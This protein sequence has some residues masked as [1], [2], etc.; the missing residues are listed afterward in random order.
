MVAAR[1]VFRLI[2]YSL[3]L[4][5]L[6]VIPGQTAAQDWRPT[7]KQQ[8]YVTKRQAPVSR[9]LSPRGAP[10]LPP[11]LRSPTMPAVVVP[12]TEPNDTVSQANLIAFGDTVTGVIDP[13]E[14]V[15]YFAFDV[16][17]ETTID[18]DVDAAQAG[19]PLDAVIALF[20]VDSV[21]VLA[22][23]DDADGLDSR[24]VYS[25]TTAGRY[26][27]AIA[28]LGGGG[29]PQ[30]TY[31]LAFGTFDFA[32][33]EVEPNN[34]PAEANPVALGDTAAGVITPEADVDY[35]SVDI[36]AETFVDLDV[37]AS[38][39]GSP[40]DAF[41]VLF[42]VDGT[43][44]LAESDDADGLDSRIRYF[45][46]ASGRY[47]VAIRDLGDRGGGGFFYM[48]SFG[49]AAPGPGDP[50]TLFAS[51]FEGPWGMAFDGQGEL[52]VAETFVDQVSR[53]T[54][55]GTV[56][57]LAT[58]IPS[59]QGAAFDGF[60]ELLVTSG[61]GNVYKVSSTG[62]ATAFITALNS[63]V[64]VT[65]SPDGNIWVADDG[66]GMLRRYDAFGAL[67]ESFDV[68]SAGGAAFLAFSPAGELHFSNGG[69]AV[70]KLIGGQPQPF[71]QAPPFL[72]ALAFDVDGNLYVANGFMGEVILYAA[73]GSAVD[74]PFAISNLGGPIN[75][76]FGRDVDG[77]TNAR[78]FA[79]NLGFNLS[80]PF[81]GG[82]V[83]MNPA[84]I[85]APGWP[86][87]AVLQNFAIALSPNSITVT[88]GSTATY[89]VTI[90]PLGG[91]F[92][93]AVSL[94]CSNLPTLTSCAFSPGA[95]T[96]GG[97]D[98]TSTLT[99]STT[100]P[101]A[102]SAPAVDQRRAAPVHALR[103]GVLWLALPGIVLVGVTL[104]GWQSEKRRFGIHLLVVMVLLAVSLHGAC[105]GEEVAAP[106]GPV[107][108]TGTFT[109]T[110]TGTAGSLEHSTTATLI[111]R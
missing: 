48:L 45:I 47:F 33:T 108:P 52:L 14:D 62:V 82:I 2:R 51:G 28:D 90:R 78:L 87:G 69:D 75:L 44:V 31:T 103:L 86:V 56:S 88:K 64:A 54:P 43:T 21:T 111:V 36:P 70:F 55:D 95:V 37:D 4:A 109:F 104:G 49:T 35:F 89:T 29:S 18:L 46:E 25:I 13:A 81:A 73:D 84:G 100:G 67:Q 106:A 93:D 58:G 105:G 101:A 16:P 96:P 74:D 42:D 12:E 6:V 59:P 80:P 61:D 17:A 39:L 26:F 5:M 34:S 7:G 19:S 77:T 71:I 8:P 76:A 10:A 107:T 97:G 30:H 85:R 92:D 110:I 41:L 9:Y 102:S 3:A 60:G 15:D 91:S 24:I 11:A 23:N 99:V 32:V 94:S 65:T 1:V 20:D 50:T 66:G 22:V 98:A 40:L 72:E 68:A 83:E 79:A 63:P 57:V 27:V 53:V 38:T